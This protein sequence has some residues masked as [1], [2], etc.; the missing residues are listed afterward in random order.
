MNSSHQ[1]PGQVHCSF[2]HVHVNNSQ[3]IFSFQKNM[4]PSER[5][6]TCHSLVNVTSAKRHIEAFKGRLRVRNIKSSVLL[7]KAFLIIAWLL[8]VYVLKVHTLQSKNSVHPRD[9]MAFKD[10]LDF[11]DD[12]SAIIFVYR[13][14]IFIEF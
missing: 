5:G 12:S 11:S 9:L 10:C 8:K 3:L 6:A 13:H 4:S 2:C 7:A 14:K 1:N